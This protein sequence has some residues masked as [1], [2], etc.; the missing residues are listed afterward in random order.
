MMFS[1]IIVPV[2]LEDSWVGTA[3][4]RADTE[5]H[6]TDWPLLLG[7]LHGWIDEWIYKSRGLYNWWVWTIYFLHLIHAYS[8]RYI[9]TSWCIAV[10]SSYSL[11]QAQ[12]QWVSALTWSPTRRWTKLVWWWFCATG[13]SGL[14][15]SIHGGSYI[16]GWKRRKEKLPFRERCNLW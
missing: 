13:G 6:M 9:H 15:L 3:R 5:F 2:C 14:L 1:D 7:P 11:C 10:L 4:S 16:F 8:H 12:N